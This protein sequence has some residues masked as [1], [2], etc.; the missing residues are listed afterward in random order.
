[1]CLKNINANPTEEQKAMNGEQRKK[2]CKTSRLGCPSCD[3]DVCKN[4]WDEGFDRH[5]K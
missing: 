1:M 5:A 3:E 2:V 4:C